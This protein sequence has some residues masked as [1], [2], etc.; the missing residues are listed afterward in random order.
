LRTDQRRHATREA[1]CLLYV[2]VTRA[3]R[4]LHVVLAPSA[5]S[6][7]EIPARFSGIV[8]TAWRGSGPAPASTVLFEAGDP[9]WWSATTREPEAMVA[10]QES[11]ASIELASEPADVARSFSRRTATGLDAERVVSDLRAHLRVESSD[12]RARGTLIHAWMESIDW[13]DEPSGEENDPPDGA[14]M[15]RA[16][17]MGV[18]ESL[19]ESTLREFRV[20]LTNPSVRAVLQRPSPREGVHCEVRREMPFAVRDGRTLLHGVFDR[21]VFERDQRGVSTVRIYDFKSDRIAPGQ[22]AAH[23][24]AYAG[25]LAVYR[26]A[27]ERMTRLAPES[28]HCALVFLDSGEVVPLDP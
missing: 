13:L 15:Q 1:L 6:E 5:P 24:A 16:R 20:M 23:V 14:L 26:R 3:V 10:T 2:A 17:A 18:A 19:A 11:A 8:R 7:R 25:Q 27:A 28:V 9:A 21:I 12:A 22:V 4:A